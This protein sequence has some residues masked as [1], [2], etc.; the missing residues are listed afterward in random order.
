MSG[1][2]ETYIDLLHVAAGKTDKVHDGVE[3]VV[4]TLVAN[5]GARGE[6]WGGSEDTLGK[7]FAEGKNGYKSSRDNLVTG[8]RNVAATFANISKGQSDGARK[9][10]GMEDGNRDGFR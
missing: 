2:L 6:P 5:I 9:L 1:R 8:G 10:Q 3:A 4:N 7:G